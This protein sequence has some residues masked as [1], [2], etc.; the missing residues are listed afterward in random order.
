MGFERDV[1]CQQGGMRGQSNDSRGIGFRA[2]CTL[3]FSVK[4]R[5][6]DLPHL[7]VLQ[8]EKGAEGNL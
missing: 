7:E 6:W 2:A 1:L 4:Q 3:G 5:W 8:E